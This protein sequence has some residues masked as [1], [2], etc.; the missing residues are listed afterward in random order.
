MIQANNGFWPESMNDYESIRSNLRFNDIVVSFTGT[1]NVSGAAVFGQHVYDYVDANIGYT[2][3]N[4]LVL[5]RGK[6]VVD[7]EVLNDV[8]EQIGGG[9]EPFS[10]ISE[11][12][13]GLAAEALAT[14]TEGVTAVGTT[15][16]AAAGQVATTAKAGVSDAA[17]QISAT[18]K[19]ATV[20]IQ[21]R[22]TR[23]SADDK[24]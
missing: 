12:N 21:G 1:T 6:L 7:E 15:T 11:E 4:V 24:D 10:S 13:Q 16:A 18:T 22:I 17:D 2:F 3:V 23:N 19:N 8:T 20:A 9:A 14:V 5:E